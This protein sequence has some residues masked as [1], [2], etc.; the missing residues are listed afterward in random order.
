MRI[1]LVLCLAATVSV[2][3]SD[4]TKV[5][6]K[7]LP[8][9]FTPLK[10]LEIKVSVVKGRVVAKMHGGKTQDLGAWE[11]ADFEPATDEVVFGDFNFDGTIDIGVLEGVGY[12]GVNLFYR[13]YLYDK[14]AGKLV[15]FKTSVSNPTLLTKQKLL[16]SAQRSGPRW[17]QTVYRSDAGNLI[18]V[19]EAEMLNH[20]TLWGVAE[21]DAGDKLVAQRVLDGDTLE[22]DPTSKAPPDVQLKAGECS[23]RVRAGKKAEPAKVEVLDFRDSGESI[24]VRAESTG[25]GIWLAA[26]CIADM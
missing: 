26:E 16:I 13:L 19:Y 25:E 21:Y 3:A 5:I 11:K 9:A 23:D 22:R 2:L 7:K 24:R 17:Y 14:I 1:A 4:T 10:S 15:Q 8:A 20:P 6:A 18:R 12:G